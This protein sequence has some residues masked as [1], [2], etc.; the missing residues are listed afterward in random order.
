AERTFALRGRPDPFALDRGEIFFAR[1]LEKKQ[2]EERAEKI[3]QLSDG[4][5]ASKP[6]N[7]RV[8][9]PQPMIFWNALRPTSLYAHVACV[10]NKTEQGVAPGDIVEQTPR[11]AVPACNSTHTIYGKE[12]SLREPRLVKEDRKSRLARFLRKVPAQEIIAC[13]AAM[14]EHNAGEN[15]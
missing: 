3:K 12:N 15:V 4:C 2:R 1:R 9:F 6:P 13:G 5:A 7:F 11:R 14:G 10:I 8:L